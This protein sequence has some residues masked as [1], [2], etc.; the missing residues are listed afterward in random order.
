MSDTIMSWADEMD[1]N[2]ELEDVFS[3]NVPETKSLQTLSSQRLPQFN[4]VNNSSRFAKPLPKIQQIDINPICNII[5]EKITHFDAK[6]IG[7]ALF[8]IMKQKLIGLNNGGREDRELIASYIH[9][10]IQEKLD[11]SGIKVFNWDNI[12]KTISYHYKDRIYGNMVDTIDK[13]NI[14]THNILPTNVIKSRFIKNV[15]M[16]KNVCKRDIP[17]SL[18]SDYNSLANN[19]IC[20]T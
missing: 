1:A 17:A 4:T 8:Q 12:I 16:Y 15:E 14:P 10:I 11:I 2:D 6:A 5:Y 13:M 9:M 20:D 18:P 3:I 7:L 19:N